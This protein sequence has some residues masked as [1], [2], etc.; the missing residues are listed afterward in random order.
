MTLTMTTFSFSFPCCNS[1]R[2]WCVLSNHIP[3]K[4][5]HGVRILD[6]IA[7]H[8]SRQHLTQS[9]PQFVERWG[10]RPVPTDGE[11]MRNLNTAQGTRGA[12]CVCGRGGLLKCNNLSLSLYTHTHT[13]AHAFIFIRIYSVL[14]FLS[15][16]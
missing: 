4:R 11:R 7:T 3:T 13:C 10:D 2:C 1:I 6:F 5:W 9:A 14:L 15:S 12:L 16:G 8:Q